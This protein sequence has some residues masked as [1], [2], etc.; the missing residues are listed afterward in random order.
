[1]GKESENKTK[2]WEIYDVIVEPG[3]RVSDIREIQL[4]DKGLNGRVLLERR[5]N[6]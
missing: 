3:S 2:A 6:R 1:M 5:S 4:V